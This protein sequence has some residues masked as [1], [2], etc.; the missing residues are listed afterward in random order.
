[1]NMPNLAY[2]EFPGA[3]S[4]FRSWLVRDC[5]DCCETGKNTPAR[6]QETSFKQKL[7]RVI[8]LTPMEF[9]HGHSTTETHYEGFGRYFQDRKGISADEVELTAART[10]STVLR[11]RGKGAERDRWRSVSGEKECLGNGSP[12]NLARRRSP[13]FATALASRIRRGIC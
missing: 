10:A 1:M 7:R 11:F 6:G 12:R 5:A 3:L 13:G 9:S 8:F 4:N 2:L